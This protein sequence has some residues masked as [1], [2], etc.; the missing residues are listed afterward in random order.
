MRR[1]A[2]VVAALVGTAVGCTNWAFVLHPRS[3]NIIEVATW[4]DVPVDQAKVTAK[5][6]Q[7]LHLPL[8]PAAADGQPACLVRINDEAPEVPEFCSSARTISYIFRAERPGQFH[9]ESLNPLDLRGS[10][11]LWN[12][13]VTE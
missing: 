10:T 7:V 5:V 6:G 12:I 1:F 11:R 2:V 8:G 3:G 4:T 9:V 13:T